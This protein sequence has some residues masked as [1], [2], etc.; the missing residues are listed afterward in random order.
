MA[1]PK[2]S[3]GPRYVVLGFP[4]A[5]KTALLAHC[6][7][8]LKQPTLTLDDEQFL[9]ALLEGHPESAQKIGVGVRRV[10][11]NAD[12]FGGRCFWLERVDGSC[13][14]FSFRSCVTPPLHANEVRMALRQLV[15][16]QII[17]FR[18]ATFVASSVACAITGE[19]IASDAA[20]VDHRPPD[21]FIVLVERFLAVHGLT[22]DAVKVEPT[23]DGVTSRE[24]TDPVLARAWCTFHREHA[25]LQI[26]GKRANL[27]QGTGRHCPPPP[28]QLSTPA[29]GGVRLRRVPSSANP[30][31]STGS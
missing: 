1:Y 11:V 17:E 24:L 25:V 19:L 29:P 7:A 18:D 14:D 22:I 10:F 16:D 30:R 5:T 15:T 13:T 28:S 4:F 9:V 23:K 8:M 12:G 20:H 3:K 26:V 21:H 6:S 2:R 31:P 27:S